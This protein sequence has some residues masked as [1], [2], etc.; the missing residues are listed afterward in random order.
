MET[1][2]RVIK[3]CFTISKPFYSSLYGDA[4]PFQ[5]KIYFGSVRVEA[6]RLCREND[7]HSFVIYSLL[8][9]SHLCFTVGSS[10]DIRRANC[11]G[12]GSSCG[13]RNPHPHRPDP[14]VSSTFM[15]ASEIEPCNT[16]IS[17]GICLIVP[18][19][20]A[21]IVSHTRLYIIY[22]LLTVI[23]TPSDS[24]WR[25]RRSNSSRNA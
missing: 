1:Q 14:Q 24:S 2:T 4:Y 19:I 21:A 8:T 20:P 6:N 15:T 17:T 22:I 18:T 23:F 13:H 12:P 10:H 5:P 11:R 9:N 7:I 25:I 16:S 3:V